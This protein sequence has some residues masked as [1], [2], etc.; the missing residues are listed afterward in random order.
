MQNHAKLYNRGSWRDHSGWN[1]RRILEESFGGVAMAWD[2]ERLYAKGS[3]ESEMEH[4]FGLILLGW[5]LERSFWEDHVQV[6]LGGI[7]LGDHSVMGL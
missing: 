3:F 4:H 2:L 5:G 6:S 1:H 7:I